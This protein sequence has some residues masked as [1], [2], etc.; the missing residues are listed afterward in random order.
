MSEWEGN[1]Q[2]NSCTNSAESLKITVPR[3]ADAAGRE[4]D[5]GA[6]PQGTPAAGQQ[7][8]RRSSST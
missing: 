8:A 6:A 7:T 5:G 3:P 1:V 2:V 4:R